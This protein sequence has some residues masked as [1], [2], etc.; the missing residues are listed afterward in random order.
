MRARKG[1]SNVHSPSDDDG[2]NV[3]VALEGLS[4]DNETGDHEE[5]GEEEDGEAAL[6]LEDTSVAADVAGGDEVVEEVTDDLAD[7]EGDE[8]SEVDEGDG[9]KSE[10]VA[11]GGFGNREEDGGGDVDTDSPHERESVDDE[12]LFD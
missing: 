2:A 8:R 12:E 5:C 4:D 6:G 11:S 10:T 1:D 9:A 7:D 3:E